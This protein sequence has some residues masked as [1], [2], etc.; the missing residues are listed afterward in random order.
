MAR[1]DAIA[2]AR[3]Q[4]EEEETAKLKQA[5]DELERA[6]GRVKASE[7]ALEIAAQDALANERATEVNELIQQTR[8][9]REREQLEI[10]FTRDLR[11]IKTLLHPFIT[12]GIFQ[13]NRDGFDP[14]YRPESMSLTAIG[15]SGALD[16]E[17]L[18]QLYRVGAAASSRRCVAWAPSRLT[19]QTG[20]T[21]IPARPSNGLRSC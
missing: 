19:D 11:E 2:D 1:N 15:S 21:R 5:A 16:E 3:R 18:A 6:K 4:A 12:P 8:L 13:P 7:K 9:K 14:R 17:G 20:S 10:D